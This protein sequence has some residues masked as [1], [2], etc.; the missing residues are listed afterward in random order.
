LERG[1]ESVEEEEDLTVA[2]G[3]FQVH[4]IALPY[5]VCMHRKASLGLI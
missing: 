3:G 4:I 2:R 1:E 5:S